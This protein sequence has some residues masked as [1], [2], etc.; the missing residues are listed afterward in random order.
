VIEQITKQKLP[1][2][3]QRAAFLLEHGMLDL[4]VH[5]REL[6]PTLARL[7]RLFAVTPRLAPIPNGV[8]VAG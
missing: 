6:R 1:P 2:E 5:R 7:L 4:V 8:A 3:A